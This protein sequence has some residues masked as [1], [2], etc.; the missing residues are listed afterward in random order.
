MSERERGLGVSVAGRQTICEMENVEE[1]TTT[2]LLKEY[3]CGDFSY[4]KHISL[5]IF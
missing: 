2:F 5:D 1:W 4:C 3:F